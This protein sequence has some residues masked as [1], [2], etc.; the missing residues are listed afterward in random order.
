MSTIVRKTLGVFHIELDG[1]VD[2]ELHRQTTH[3]RRKA[4]DRMREQDDNTP[5]A[6]LS[7]PLVLD[8]GI[9]HH[10]V[11]NNPEQNPSLQHTHG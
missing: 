4:L 2:V 1:R 6:N 7:T 10:T 11:D 8:F 9:E 3:Q 5:H